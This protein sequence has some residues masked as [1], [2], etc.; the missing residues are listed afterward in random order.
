MSDF[1]PS[2]FPADPL[3]DRRLF[4]G[5]RTRRALGFLVDVVVLAVLTVLVS[6]LILLLGVFTLGLGWLLFPL[7]WPFLALIYCA[8]TLG[9]R[10]R[11]PRACAP[12]GWRCASSTDRA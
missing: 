2:A 3:T 6:G 5:V 11:R 10:T 9:G 7:V 4:D 1:T 12:S 8:F